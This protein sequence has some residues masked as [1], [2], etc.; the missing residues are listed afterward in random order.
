MRKPTTDEDN[1]QMSDVLCDFCSSQWTHDL[2][3][4]EG[5]RGSAICG[6]CLAVAYTDIALGDNNTA[7]PGYTCT[8]CLEQRQDPGWRG[9]MREEAAICRR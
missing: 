7:M 1:V 6:K 9:L 8:M 3:I 5:H 2:P 4:V